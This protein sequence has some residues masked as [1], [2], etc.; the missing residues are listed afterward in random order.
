MKEGGGYLRYRYLRK[1]RYDLDEGCFVCKEV[2]AS[3]GDVELEL[4]D[5]LARR[6]KDERRG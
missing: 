5:L 1:G 6:L 2:G 3:D 4:Q